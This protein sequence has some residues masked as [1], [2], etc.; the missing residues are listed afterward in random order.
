M[1]IGYTVYNLNCT[2]IIIIQLSLSTM[3]IHISGVTILTALSITMCCSH[4]S[5]LNYVKPYENITCPGDLCMTL[6]AYIE[7][8]ETFFISD[9]QF[10]FLPGEHYY[11]GN[12]R[13]SNITNMTFHGQD[14]TS[15]GHAV[16]IV[17]TPGSNLTFVA[18]QNIALENFSILLSGSQIQFNDIFV[19]IQFRNTTGQLSSL[20]VA[21]SKSSLA[22]IAFFCRNSHFVIANIQITGAK[23]LLGAAFAVL[24][25]TIAFSGS[26]TFNDNFAFG[27]G[28]AVYSID[29][30]IITLSGVN[31]FEGNYAGV[32][33]GAIHISNTVLNIGG[34]AIFLRNRVEYGNA[35]AIELH[36]STLLLES[37]GVLHIKENSTPLTG[38][39]IFMNLSNAQ[40]KGQMIIQQ[41]TALVGSLGMFFSNV[42]CTGKTSY[43]NN[44]AAQGGAIYVAL[45]SQMN[46]SNAKFENNS[47]TFNGGAI[48]ISSYSQMTIQDSSMVKNSAALFGGAISLVSSLLKFSGDNYIENNMA[49]IQSGGLNAF[50]MSRIIFTGN[51]YFINNTANRYGGA[52]SITFTNVSV[53]G[54]LALFNNN[55]GQGGAIYGQSSKTEFDTYARV[56]FKSNRATVQGGAIFS[57]DST[58]NNKGNL[59]FFNNVATQGGA[60]SLVGS[61][62]L[63]LTKNSDTVYSQNHA[64][65]NGGAIYFAD[66]ISIN[67]CGVY[68]NTTV[69][70]CFKP[71]TTMIEVC[72]QLDDCFIELDADFPF[73]HSTSNISLTFP[74]NYAGKSGA[75][76]YGGS[77]DNCRLYL[78]GGFQDDCGNKIGREYTE[79]P[80]P[81]ILQISK[82]DNTSS[83]ISSEPF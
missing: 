80:L 75:A 35:G 33:G 61:S 17:F 63:I 48:Y 43:V 36:D 67:Q 1:I 8:A 69:A 22:S 68:E 76:F 57:I 52:F 32:S 24:N 60:M 38:G 13:L 11:D 50:L 83:A 14:S 40:I 64:D 71:N 9:T 27:N 46:L 74:D 4:V 6:E 21:G 70:V 19:S 23:S 31:H 72:R 56:I 78:G 62:K 51:N 82:I 15:S 16:Q 59:T 18:S 39:A 20:S 79:D 54:T 58:W 47:A 45:S 44:S 42:T 53:Q 65:T 55:G 2:I 73:D 28:G 25:S 3:E 10:T 41:N 30:S 81:I 49:R 29:Y 34:S 7:A 37:N 66:R 77:F 5:H 26:N 12:L